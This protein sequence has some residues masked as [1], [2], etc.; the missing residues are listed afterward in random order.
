M[1]FDLC[2]QMFT[3]PLGLGLSAGVASFRSLWPS[4][5]RSAAKSAYRSR[6][7]NRSLSAEP[8][9]FD[10]RKPM[11][12]RSPLTALQASVSSRR[13][14]I[15]SINNHGRSRAS[16]ENSAKLAARRLRIDRERSDDSS[17]DENYVPATLNLARCFL[18]RR[19]YVCW[20]HLCQRYANRYGQVVVKTGIRHLLAESTNARCVLFNWKC[21]NIWKNTS[22]AKK[23]FRQKVVRYREEHA[24]LLSI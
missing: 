7:R 22:D 5:I 17:F 2:T 1:P 9:G 16:G 8:R 23:C 24:V 14:E 6:K 18:D 10:Q 3:D 15:R 12:R 20:L 19:S 21:S 13:F 4:R 11:Q